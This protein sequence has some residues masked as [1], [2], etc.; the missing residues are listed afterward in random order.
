MSHFK[1]KTKM[2]WL[3]KKGPQTRSQCK[4][5]SELKRHM[6]GEPFST[7]EASPPVGFPPVYFGGTWPCK[8]R[9]LKR[10][11]ISFSNVTF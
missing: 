6:E 10:I 7:L 11:G 9:C 8:L 5:E 4:T 2:N 3:E 1:S